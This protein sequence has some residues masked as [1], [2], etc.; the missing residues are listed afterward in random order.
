M[1][2]RVNKLDEAVFRRDKHHSVVFGMET[3]WHIDAAFV[4]RYVDEPLQCVLKVVNDIFF[5]DRFPENKTV[6][7]V[8]N[9]FEVCRG[10]GWTRFGDE[11]DNLLLKV[12]GRAIDV[13]DCV[14]AGVSGRLDDFIAAFRSDDEDLL[15]AV[16]NELDV[17]LFM[18]LFMTGA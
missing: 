16:K 3:T 13:I 1:L 2:E 9:M 5:N 7:F 17:H 8:D 18:T 4:R 11:K 14:A 12:A 6:R 15:M 10:S